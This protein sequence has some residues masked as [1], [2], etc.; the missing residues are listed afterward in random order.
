MDRSLKA[1]AV[2]GAIVALA[3]GCKK[4]PPTTTPE[5][6][7]PPSAVEAPPA[8]GPA[9]APPAASREEGVMT[10]DLQTLN[11]KGYLKDAYYDFDKADLRDDARTAL[12]S[13]A[14]WLKQ[15]GSIRVLVEGHCDERGTEEYNLSLGQKRASAVK[16][17]LV[18][19]GIEGSRIN[20][21][22]YGKARPFCTDHDENCWQQNRRGHFVITGK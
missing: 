8:P 22:S 19:L 3:A 18:S 5:A 21:V 4:K 1:A 9:T 14:Q 2:L 20:T 7:P 6:A 12:A 17:Y 10:E 13:D 16:D 15:Y 11:S